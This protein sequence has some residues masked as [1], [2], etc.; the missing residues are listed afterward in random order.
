MALTLYKKKRSFNK[1]PEPTGGKASAATLRFVIQK[2]DATRLHYDF[3]LEMEGVLKSWAVPKGPS[4]NP[5]D[6]RLAMMVE[7]H[8]YDYRT[9][10]GIIPEG[11]YGA[12]T[13]IVWDEGTYESLDGGTKSEQERSLLQ[14]LKK[15][16]LKFKLNGEKLKGE[17]ALVKLKN[18]EKNAWLLIKHRDKYAK[19]TD[20]TK[21]DK[22]VISGKSL[23]AIE[24]TSK[25]IWGSSPKKKTASTRSRKARVEK[26][27]NLTEGKKASFPKTFR[28]MLA[29]LVDKPFDEPGW[30]YEIKWD[31]YRAVAMINKGKVDLISRN[32]KTFNDKFYPV[33]DALKKWDINAIIDGEVVVLNEKGVSNFGALQNWRSEADGDLF[34]YVF[35][36]LW[37]NGYDL[38][39]LPLAKRKEI[40]KEQIPFEGIIRMSETFQ[41]TATEFLEATAKMGMEGIMAKK[42]ESTYIE[43]DRTKA[44]LKIKSNLRHEV[45]IGG[46]TQNEGSGKTFSS[47][48]VG[49]FDNGRLDYMGKIGTGFNDKTQKEIMAKM[50][51]LA[52]DKVP[53]TEKPD[54]N[55][56]SRFRPDPPKA[57]VTWVKPELVCEVSYTE[58]TS[59]GIMRH[60]SFE[61]LR[62]DKKARDVKKE[63]AIPAEEVEEETTKKQKR[64]KYTNPSTD[65]SRKTLLNPTEETQVKKINGHELK[66]T[67]LSKIFWPQEKY[68]KRDMLNYYYQVAPYLL[69]YLKDRP[70]S[71]NRYPNGIKGKSFYQKDVTGKAPDWI[72]MEPYTTSDG[73]DKNFLVP[74]D[75]ASILYMAN[76]GAIEMNPWNSTIHNPDNPDWCLIDLDPS[77]KQDFD[78][79]IKVALA[80]KEVL[81]TMGVTGYP[82]TS[83]STGIHVYIPLGAKYTYDQC[84]MFARIIATQVN[85]MLPDITSIERLTK[86]RKNKLYVDFLQ[87][88][89]KATLAA[90]YSLRP[91]PGAP[92]SMPL[93]WEEVKKGLKITDFNISNAMDRIKSEGDIF[94]PVLGK[95]ID[96]NK[97][98]KDI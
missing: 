72:K 91:K 60:P 36:V 22:S 24:K 46:Y 32:N 98:L 45:V 94:K 18:A 82:K 81:D 42:E 93:Y 13:V 28:P 80:T 64:L 83:G 84:Q 23:K 78:V 27:K 21:K 6:K 89:P 73:E 30:L 25:N 53:F 16:S 63:K 88:R 57:K 17:F 40:L 7:D 12:G 95:G 11:N 96:L 35:D 55:K 50:K 3:R 69:P 68:T 8:P 75:E 2:H 90:P 44:W 1:T 77:D 49:V 52:T 15:G 51:K 34:Y 58:I 10:E 5:E 19:A 66:F 87:N 74:E 47:L 31:G 70:Q 29:T 14:Q 79:V 20:V 9:F 92:V 61:G 39:D 4:L 97:I 48:L 86:A 43:G 38:K 37:L 62:T 26:K 41:T 85:N 71:L 65:K 56:P 59:D 54:V 33:V 76:A 67:N